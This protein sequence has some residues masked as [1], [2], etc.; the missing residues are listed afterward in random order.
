MIWIATI[1]FTNVIIS[2][3]NKRS[4]HFLLYYNNYADD[5]LKREKDMN[6]WST[7]LNE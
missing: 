3:G 1:R 6:S 7:E 2:D 5:V 4:T